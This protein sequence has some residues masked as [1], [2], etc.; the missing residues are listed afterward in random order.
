M[1]MAP[2]SWTDAGFLLGEWEVRPRHGTLRQL[3]ATPSTPI[4]VEPRVMAVLVCMARRAGEVVTRDEFISEVWAGRVVSDEALSRCISLLRQVF[5]DDSHEPRFIRTVARV[6]YTLLQTPLPLPSAEAAPAATAAPP[7]AE[8]APAPAPGVAV[9]GPPHRARRYA[10]AGIAALAVAGAG[11]LYLARTTRIGTGEAR[12]PPVARLLVLPF[13]TREAR[14]FGRDVGNALG[15][16][17]ADSLAHVERLQIIGRTSANA[18]SAS[19]AGAVDAGRRLGVDAVLDGAVAESADGLRV[20]VRLTTVS[21][22]HVLWSRVYERKPADIFAVQSSIAS[23]VVRELV[24][25]LSRDGLAGVPSVEPDSRDLQ[26][27]QLYL[28]GAHQV[29]LRGE[30]SLRRAIDLFSA[31]VRRDPS[32]VRPQIGLATAYSLLPSYTFE[33]PAEMYALAE[34]AMANAERLTHSRTVTAGTRA[35]L[36]FMRSQWIDSEIAFRTAI[37]L[38]PNNP[39]VRQLYSQLLGAVGKLD[40]ALAQSR[41]AQELDPLAPVVADR[42]GILQL[43][44]GQ[45]E[46]AARNE[47][48]A[49]EFGL[50]E[51]AYPEVKVLLKLHQHADAD[52]ANALRDLQHAVN[53]SDAWIEPTLYA[54]RHPEAR[55]GAIELLDRAQKSG[56]ISARIYFGTM[57]VLGSPERAMHAF[58]GLIDRDPNDLEF[59]FSAD[60]AAVRRDPGFGAFAEKIGLVAYWDRFGWPSACRRE[61]TK[62]T[63]H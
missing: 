16:E 19:H 6:G 13:D 49:R 25:L 4:Q 37:A 57:V 56:A 33:D 35:Y 60:A 38:D 23:A 45:D 55:P 3:S 41:I 40:A 11:S 17:I 43:W 30:D 1:S 59:L 62:I 39:D 18:V 8:P 7:P 27:Y 5:A 28:R 2:R 24:G 26:A 9:G 31:A 14:D 50:D 47:T 54:Y 21:D 12:A 51:V 48:L 20:T 10:I 63:C 53:R 44:L 32:Y 36:G 34:K 52:A 22:A 29:R 15:D 42:I 58:Y 61:G 46:E